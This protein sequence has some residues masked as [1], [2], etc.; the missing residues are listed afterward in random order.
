MKPNDAS[1]PTERTMIR[2]FHAHVYFRNP[3]ERTRALALRRA[4][5]IE[6]PSVLLGR[7]HDRPIVVHPAPMYQV[8]FPPEA[9]GSVV[10]WLMLN[11][12]GLSILVHAVTE[13]VMAEHRDWPLW[14]GERL[15]LSLERLAS[16]TG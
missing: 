14:L 4:I 15:D 8:S 3:E 6:H 2:G 9:F 1:S 10:P 11:Q 5:A 12:N 7:V 13:D 16:V